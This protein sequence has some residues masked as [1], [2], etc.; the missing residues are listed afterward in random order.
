MILT[1]IEF[2]NFRCFK[3]QCYF[4]ISTDPERNVTLIHAQNG[5]GKTN[6]LNAVLWTM[7]GRTTHRFE[8]KQKIIHDEAEQEGATEAWVQ[9]EFEHL[10]EDYLVR[11]TY[12]KDRFGKYNEIVKV[13]TVKSGNHDEV[14]NAEGFLNSVIPVDMAEYFFFDGEHAETFTGEKNSKKVGDAIRDVL[15]FELADNAKEDIKNAIKEYVRRAASA[16]GGTGSLDLSR[17]KEALED[18]VEKAKELL[19]DAED[20]KKNIEV[21]IDDLGKAL[22]GSEVAKEIEEQ[23]ERNE[24]LSH[25]L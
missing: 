1:R 24:K 4:D 23:R 22:K 10:G 21:Q 9:L 8:Q 13:F 20:Q 17:R 7:H 11:R 18:Q 14:K 2:K 12:H 5:V 6:I 3:G 15:G 25:P 16:Q 19:N